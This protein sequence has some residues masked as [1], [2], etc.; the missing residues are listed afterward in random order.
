MNSAATWIYTASLGFS[1][2][3]RFYFFI[4]SY[5]FAEE[6]Q[7]ADLVV[8]SSRPRRRTLLSDQDLGGG[9]G[10]SHGERSGCRERAD[11]RREPPAAPLEHL[12]L[13]PQRQA[14]G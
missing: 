5:G 9:P 10:Q 11:R 8:D 6:G 12:H 3:D 1:P 14:C 4:E 13:A 7:K 2:T